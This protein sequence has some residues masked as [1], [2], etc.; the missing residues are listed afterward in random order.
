MLL[1]FLSVLFLFFLNLVIGWMYL[2]FLILRNVPFGVVLHLFVFSH[3]RFISVSQNSIL[4]FEFS[5]H[6]ALP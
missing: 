4:L 1:E 5:D 6:K 3:S 2:F